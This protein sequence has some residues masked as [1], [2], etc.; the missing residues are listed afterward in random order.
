DIRPYAQIFALNRFSV[1]RTMYPNS[2]RL[3]EMKHPNPE[4]IMNEMKRCIPI[5]NG[6]SVPTKSPPTELKYGE[7]HTSRPA[8]RL[9]VE[10]DLVV[11]QGTSQ[12]GNTI[13]VKGES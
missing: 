3:R 4:E 12:E 8:I 5:Y 13:P 11:R 10:R 9:R 6:D 7:P 2:V 1:R